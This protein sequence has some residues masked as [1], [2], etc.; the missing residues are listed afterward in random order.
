[1]KPVLTIL[2]TLAFCLPAMAQQ[3]FY[4]TDS[5]G[6]HYGP[7]DFKNGNTVM[8]GSYA[9][10]LTIAEPSASQGQEKHHGEVIQVINQGL[11]LVNE[12]YYNPPSS[13]NLDYRVIAIETDTSQ[14]AQG[15]KVRFITEQ[16]G[17]FEYSTAF[18]TASKVRKYKAIGNY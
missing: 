13:T 15:D 7:F 17:F 8:I 11:L 3:K 12:P 6:K 9:F 14:I 16:A 18:G 1:M 4:L 5:R 10:R 2:L